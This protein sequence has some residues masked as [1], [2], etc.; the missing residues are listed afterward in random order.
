MVLIDERRILRTSTSRGH[1][2]KVSKRESGPAVEASFVW[3]A[4]SKVTDVAKT[5]GAK[6]GLSSKEGAEA[7]GGQVL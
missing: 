1:P 6:R 4:N 7:A 5:E 3:L 2:H